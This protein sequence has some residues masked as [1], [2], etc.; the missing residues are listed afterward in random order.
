MTAT[1]PPSATGASPPASSD[2]V[3]VGGGIIGSAIA[4][5]LANDPG[6]DGSVTVIERD[7]SYR[8]CSTTLSAASIRQ[9]FSVPENIAMSLYGIEFLRTA[10]AR[11]AV[12]GDDGPAVSL[13]EDGYL[14]LATPATRSL[15]KHNHA[16][17]TAAGADIAWLEP[18]AL[19]AR[20]PWLTTDDI[21]AGTLG[22]SG[23]GWFDSYALLQG[24]R[25][26]ALSLG[27]TYVADEVV[28]FERATGDT[29]A[30]TA[31]LT[32]SGRR[33]TWRHRGQCRRCTG[34]RRGDACRGGASRAP[35]PA[36]RL[37]LQ[38]PRARAEP[39]SD[40]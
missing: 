7:P 24:F 18:E 23:E 30:I 15:L 28:G 16:L 37:R 1:A 33:I 40:G 36:L 17:Q 27:A 21:S 39:A 35:P 25:K 22:L 32:G 8:E 20:F 31:V 4:Y 34:R 9:Q 11:L 3:V 12:D 26:K 29:G 13:V 10:P 2:V 19:K 5:F 38:L 6:F 14:F